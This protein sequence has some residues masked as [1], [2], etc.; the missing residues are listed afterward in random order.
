VL[1]YF[2]GFLWLP[3]FEVRTSAAIKLS[4]DGLVIKWPQE[5]N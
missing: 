5:T 1:D 3:K 2:R 4:L